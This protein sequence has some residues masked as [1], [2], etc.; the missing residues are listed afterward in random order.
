MKCSFVGKQIG[1]V[2]ALPASPV[3]TSRR[4]SVKITALLPNL[5][6]KD[7]EQDVAGFMFDPSMQ[8]STP[9][10]QSLR[11]FPSRFVSPQP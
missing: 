9:L 1:G 5:K 6:N 3:Q 4:S 10:L 11:C 2:R 7:S 8:V